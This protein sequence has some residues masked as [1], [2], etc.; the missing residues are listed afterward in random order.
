VEELPATL[1]AAAA[2]VESNS[3]EPILLKPELLSYEI[4]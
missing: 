1:A 4:V 2:M 3:A